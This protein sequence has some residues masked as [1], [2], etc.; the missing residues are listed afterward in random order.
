[1]IF[2]IRYE[3]ISNIIIFI[4]SFMALSALTYFTAVKS[5]LHLSVYTVSLQI[6]ITVI[7]VI[8]Q[9]VRTT[10]I[11]DNDNLT[12]KHLIMKKVVPL[13][14][15]TDVQTARYKRRH[16][17]HYVEQR[18][19]M[20]ISLKGDKAIVLNDTAMAGIGGKGLLLRNSRVLSDSEIE[21]YKAYQ[22]VM[23]AIH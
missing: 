21:L 4:L 10:L 17:N 12:I 20:V 13:S 14:D 22:A 16:K 15:I 9:S 19:K 6:I 18:M 3:K 11:I 5:K 1:M 2:K 23:A 7:F 8:V